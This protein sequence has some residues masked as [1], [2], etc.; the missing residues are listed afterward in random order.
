MNLP[1]Q[2]LLD[3]YT[4]QLEQLNIKIDSYSFFINSDNKEIKTSLEGMRIVTRTIV[5]ELQ[6]LL[7]IYNK[8]SEE[9]TY[10]DSLNSIK[11]N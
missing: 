4:Q 8:Q 5:S 1:I 6:I 7:D 11:T 9:Q 2:E 10:I 3:K